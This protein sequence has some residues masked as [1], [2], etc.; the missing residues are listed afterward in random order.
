MT[1]YVELYIDQGTDFFSTIVLQDDVTNINQNV[2][3]YVITS[4]MRKSVLSEQPYANF[5]CDITNAAQG[6]IEISMNSANT[7]NL[8][9]GTYLFD[10]RARIIAS[11]VKL[12]EGIVIVSPSITK[13]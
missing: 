7:S 3:G 6:T 2:D 10:V 13:M 12:V 5:H 11:Y 9:P 8:K 4:S 1:D